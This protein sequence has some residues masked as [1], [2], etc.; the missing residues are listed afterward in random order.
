[1]AAKIP[2]DVTREDRLVGPLTLRQFLYVLIGGAIVFLLYQLYANFYLFFHEFLILGFI[3]AS[4]AVMLA[5]GSINGRPFGIFLLNLFRFIT[6][7]KILLWH[8]DAR[9]E[10]PTI[11]VASA[12]IK[13]SKLEAQQRKAGEEMVSEFEKLASILDTGGTIKAEHHSAITTSVGSLDFPT[14][15]DRLIDVNVEDVLADTD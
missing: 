5:F 9:A 6:S 11:K 2:Q 12:D 3:V 7:P 13:D 8:K 4:F 10:L 15:E 14:T 1:M